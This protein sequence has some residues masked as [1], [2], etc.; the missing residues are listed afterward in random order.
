MQGKG[1]L[2]HLLQD[3]QVV[4]IGGGE[5]VHTADGA[6]E[7]W[8][9]GGEELGEWATDLCRGSPPQDLSTADT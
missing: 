5:P 8:G 6:A 2:C 9:G 7:H 1:A 3:P 4:A